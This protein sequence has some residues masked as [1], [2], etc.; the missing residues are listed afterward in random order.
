MKLFT[1]AK[2]GGFAAMICALLASAANAQVAGVVNYWQQ[3]TGNWSTPANWSAGSVPDA[4]L[5]EFAVIGGTLATPAAGVAT[6]SAVVNS[7]SLPS[8]G[9]LVLGLA[10]NNS[11][12]LQIASGGALDVIDNPFE[13]DGSITV[14]SAGIG[15]LSVDRGGSLSGLRF[16]VSSATA[17]SLTLGS[18][19]GAGNATVNVQTATLGRTTRVIGPNVNFTA[20]DS[21]GLQSNSTFIAQITGAAVAG[22]TS[23]SALKANTVG[24]NGTLALEFAA[25]ITPTIGNVWNLFDVNNVAGEF[26]A[27]DASKAKDLPLGQIF[28]TRTQAGGTNGKLVQLG[29]EQRL[30][31]NVNRGTGAVSISNPGASAIALDGFSVSSTT[32]GALN[33]ANFTPVGGT[34]QTANSSAN[35]ISQL[36]PSGTLNLAGGGSQALGNVFQAPT[37]VALGDATEDLAFTYTD[38]GVTRTGVINYIGSQKVNNLTLLVDPATGQTQIRN[39]SNFPISLD[40]YT[41]ASTFGALDTAQWSSLDDQNAAGGDWQEANVNVNR[42]SELKFGGS[43]NLSTNQSLPIGSAYNE[44]SGK[45]DL[46]FQFLLSGEATARTGAVVYGTITAPSV[47]GDFDGNGLVNAAD[48]TKWKSDYGVNANSDANGDGKSDGADFLI[49]QRNFGAGAATVASAA[50]PEPSTAALLLCCLVAAKCGT[51]ARR[52]G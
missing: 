1:L 50:V 44:T 11:G 4:N 24:M 30:V 40:G 41:V 18:L 5:N 10:V 3:P 15:A 12:T 8:I 49:W 13:G 23:H 39:T 46:T 38:G 52:R 16:A 35:R 43:V 33:L 20:A 17:S 25:G 27:I 45:K 32:L 21:I 48:L 14:G 2:Q 37:P 26:A 31:L 51:A 28:A 34:W 22:G 47:P 7:N 6:G 29:I 9:G 19:A 36:N 42:I